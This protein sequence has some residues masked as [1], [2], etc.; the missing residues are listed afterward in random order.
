MNLEEWRAKSRHQE[1]L[2]G[3]LTVVIRRVDIL[4]LA[5]AGKIPTTLSALV[6]KARSGINVGLEDFNEFAALVNLVVRNAIVYPPLA[7]DGETPDAEH[8]SLDELDWQDRFY[9]YNACNAGAINLQPFRSEPE[10]AVGASL[11]GGDL[12]A[13]AEQLPAN[14]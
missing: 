6:E 8:L 5:A 3:G 9:V 13:E 11:P 7:R 14:P 1:E 2:P 12:R 10:T 4:S